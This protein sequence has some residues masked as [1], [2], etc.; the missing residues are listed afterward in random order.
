MISINSVHAIM[1]CFIVA[2]YKVSCVY[3][4][5]NCV[6]VFACGPYTGVLYV[7]KPYRFCNK[8][9]SYSMFLSMSSMGLH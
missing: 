9:I 5:V 8:Y 3:V 2:S 4:C 1:L 6:C 7:F